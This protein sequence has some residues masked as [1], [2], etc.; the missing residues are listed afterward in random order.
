MP[1]NLSPAIDMKLIARAK[2]QYL[3]GCYTDSL[4]SFAQ[5]QSQIQAYVQSLAHEMEHGAPSDFEQAEKLYSEWQHCLDLLEAEFGA[6]QQILDQQASFRGAPGEKV[7]AASPGSDLSDAQLQAQ[8]LAAQ[9]ATDIRD[10]D[11]WPP[12]T[13]Q[14]PSAAPGR[15]VKQ[16]SSM[17]G[18]QWGAPS[19]VQ[20]PPAVA[21]NVPSRTPM[22][23]PAA[24][25]SV[26]QGGDDDG[27]AP[28]GRLPS[29]AAGKGAA[30]TVA[31]PKPAKLIRKASQPPQ[32]IPSQAAASNAAAAASAEP[33][34]VRKASRAS[35]APTQ[36]KPAVPKVARAA[37]EPAAKKGS[38]KEDG[39]GDEGGRPKFEAASKEEQEM[40]DMIEREI[41]DKAPNVK[42]DDIAGLAGAKQLLSE[43]VVLPRLIPGYFTGKRKPWKGVLMFGPPGT[44]K[45]LLAKAV[46]TECG[47]TFFNVAPSTVTSKY[48]GDSEKLM[49]ILFAMARF[50]A[51]ST[52]FMDEVDGMCSARG[53]S[54][55][56]EASRRV[57]GEILQQMDGA[58]EGDYDPA[59]SV[60]V[61]GATNLPWELD[62][63]FL[64]RF[65][66]RVHIDLPDEEGRKQMFRINTDGMVVA[67][68]VR[69]DDTWAT[70]VALSDG[71]S[72]AD[73]AT[74]CKDASMLGLRRLLAGRSVAEIKAMAQEQLSQEAITRADFETVFQTVK[75]TAGKSDLEKY[76][77]W[78]REFGSAI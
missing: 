15:H 49:K 17:A 35:V 11:V 74:V 38:S 34:H 58:V 40:A 54:G 60:I 69:E 61:L 39:G 71:Y 27:G 26:S 67:G 16:R 19:A 2:E 5:A 44:G 64:R 65:E 22:K 12:P 21:S 68:D 50:Y 4:A 62:T 42:M 20:R 48:R 53:G 8:H 41:L 6:V 52:I 23:P 10:P 73:I 76:R 13:P 63:A 59:R 14:E 43:A 70:V 46:A 55:E 7:T 66:K 29:W 18:Q 9:Q 33:A 1:L 78:M 77:E 45:T 36:R 51:P 25:A 28:S 47:T 37:K 56:H 32:A 75:S 57:K 72:G 30:V 24:M 31:A 3:I